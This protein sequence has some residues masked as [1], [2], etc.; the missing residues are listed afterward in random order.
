[1]RK[2]FKCRR[3]V[4]CIL[5]LNVV[6]FVLACR[7]SRA[8][9]VIVIPS[10]DGVVIGADTLARTEQGVLSTN[11][12]KISFVEG[13]ND[14]AFALTGS[15][16][17]GIVGVDGQ[18]II[19]WNATDKVAN[20]LR[21]HKDFTVSSNLMTDIGNEIAIYH[22]E[23][24]RRNAKVTVGEKGGPL[25]CVT[26]V[27]YDAKNKTTIVGSVF[28]TLSTNNVEMIKPLTLNQFRPT[29][30]LSLEYSGESSFLE[31]NVLN[32]D[33]SKYIGMEIRKFFG[34]IPITKIKASDASNIID[35][36]IKATSKSMK[37]HS[38]E[39]EVS[40]GESSTVY[41]IDGQSA[42]IKMTP[43]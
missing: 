5:L 42:P 3:N 33:G 24:S 1:M 43:E 39:V 22:R 27:Q 20:Y 11:F 16:I 19:N 29:N 6:F 12:H 23:I 8:S 10:N 14:V 7:S 21:D 37:E 36:L 17:S 13:R 26:L 38:A 4:S 9:L 28:V 30:T 32:G 15:V 34:P 41:L 25:C 18:P 31:N 2:L 40:V 35:S